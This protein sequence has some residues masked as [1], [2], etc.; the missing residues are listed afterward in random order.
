MEVNQLGRMELSERLAEIHR[1]VA[2]SPR[3]DTVLQLIVAHA[4]ELVEADL[5]LLLLVDSEGLLRVRAARGA[6]RT[7]VWEVTVPR[8][9]ALADR[10]R[11]VLGLGAEDSLLSAP[12]VVDPSVHGML[13]AIHRAP[14]RRDGAATASP[15]TRRGGS[16]SWSG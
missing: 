5:T 8:E 13:L 3:F 7:A 6:G 12:I 9:D 16:G 10:L 1:A 2:R 11:Q 14:R 4:A 15:C